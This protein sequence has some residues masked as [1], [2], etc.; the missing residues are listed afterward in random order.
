M[1]LLT[2]KLRPGS[3]ALLAVFSDLQNWAQ[4][5][6]RL[7]LLRHM[8]AFGISSH[9]ASNK[10]F[11]NFPKPFQQKYWPSKARAVKHVLDGNL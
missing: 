9:T 7:A 10:I 8:K 6:Q 5:K 1:I 11:E 4:N 3:A 2:D